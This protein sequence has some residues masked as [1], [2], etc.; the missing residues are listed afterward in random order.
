MN[1]I[2]RASDAANKGYEL[3]KY[4]TNIPM[5]AMVDIYPVD[6]EDREYQL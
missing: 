1:Y 3:W 5:N 2:S 4:Q 6:D